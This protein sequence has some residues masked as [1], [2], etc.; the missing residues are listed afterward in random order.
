MI[1]TI[2]STQVYKHIS[3]IMRNNIT[4]LFIYI[5]RTYRVLEYVI[6]E[7]SAIYDKKALLQMCHEAVSE[8]YSFLYINLMVKDKRKMFMERFDRCFIPSYN[9]LSYMY[10]Y[11]YIY[12]QLL[13]IP[14]V[15][16]KH[17]QMNF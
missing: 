2:T 5:L 13:Q 7:M 10:I 12:Q 6:E 4:H 3:P 15:N 11:I 17:K 9:Y 14:K 8:P 16:F 1:S